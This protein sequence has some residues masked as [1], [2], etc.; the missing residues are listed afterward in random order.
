MARR[1]RIA[2]IAKFRVIVKSHVA[3]DARR[4][5]VRPRMPPG[6]LERDLSE[7]IGKR[8]IA[9]HRDRQPVHTALEPPDEHRRRITLIE[10]NRSKQRIIR[11]P[12]EMPHHLTVRTACTN[13]LHSAAIP[14]TDSFV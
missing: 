11:Q 3:T 4:G 5:V 6:P 7:V 8:S 9:D 2:S 10:R 13:G 14:L 1:T 12:I